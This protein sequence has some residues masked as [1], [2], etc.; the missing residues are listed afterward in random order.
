[1]GDP[2]EPTALLEKSTAISP[3][4]AGC[5]ISEA[6]IIPADVKPLCGNATVY[7]VIIIS[8]SLSLS[9]LLLLLLLLSQDIASLSSQS[10]RAKVD[11]FTGL[12]NKMDARASNHPS[13]PVLMFFKFF[14]RSLFTSLVYSKT[15]IST[16][17]DGGTGEKV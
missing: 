5:S 11:I 13:S 17:S 12:Q 10:E 3:V 7:A 4:L 14:Y 2:K 9:L 8:L 6:L 15:V 1:M 16:R